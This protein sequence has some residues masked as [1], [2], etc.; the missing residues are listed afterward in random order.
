M[1]A[2]VLISILLSTLLCNACLAQL[3][4]GEVLEMESKKPLPGVSINN[5]HNDI[6]TSAGIDGTFV[7]A[8][9]SG[10]LL[11]FRIPGYKVTRVRIPHGYVPTF[12]R[13]IME[14]PATPVMDDH[15]LAGTGDYRRDSIRSR[16]LYGHVLAFPR[17]SAIEKIKSPF[18]ALSARNKAMWEFQ[19]MYA[20][21]ERE[22]YVDHRFSPEMVSRV[23]GLKNDSLAKFMIRFRPTYEQ[24]SSMNEYTFFTYIKNSAY[25]FRSRD[26]AISP[27]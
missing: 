3:I 12:F 10:E 6:H 21:K 15:M 27:R 5:I 25:R 26:R 23:T 14:R 22:K 9:A 18:S 2:R 4:H 16:E 17:M 19:D 1:H 7:I 11:E 24:V 8:G 13:I 20:E